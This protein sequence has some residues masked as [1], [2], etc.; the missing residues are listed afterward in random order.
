MSR[1]N[2][3]IYCSR[4]RLT[5]SRADIEMQIR[6]I[7]ASA[8]TL[9]KAAGLTGALTFNEN[10]FAQVLEGA[11]DDLMPVIERIR[12]DRRHADVKILAQNQPA[13]RMFASWS[14]AFAERPGGHE[15]HPLAH[16]SFEAALIDGAAPEAEQLLDTL[17]RIVMVQ[18]KLAT[19]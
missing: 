12:R 2:R 3:I 9:N 8:R 10:C 7:L 17:R 16:F 18:S 4:S 5:G 1:L 13:N 6:N 15:R 11:A 14:M 19:G